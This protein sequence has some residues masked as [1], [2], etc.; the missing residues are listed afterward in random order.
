MVE[1]KT[2]FLAMAVLVVGGVYFYVTYLSNGG[3]G[4]SAR[5]RSERHQRRPALR[6]RPRSE[7]QAVQGRGGCSPA[8]CGW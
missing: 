3:G 2:M 1:F 5:V 8:S 4:G 7:G 6:D